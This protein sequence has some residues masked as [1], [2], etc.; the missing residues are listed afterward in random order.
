ME[1]RRVYPSTV[2][3]VLSWIIVLFGLWEF[4]DIVAPFIPGFGH[5]PIT[6]WNHILV[7]LIWLLAGAWAGLTSNIGAAKIMDWIAA[8]AGA[9]LMIASF[10]LGNPF[11]ALGL[12]ND[13]AVAVIV[14]ILGIWAAL[15]SPRTAG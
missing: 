13:I 6:L 7:G 15:A 2:S 4:G 10:I 1:E 9:W 11:V 14:V 5:V 8:L 3:K 12:W